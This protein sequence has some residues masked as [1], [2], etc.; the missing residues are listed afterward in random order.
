MFS[1]TLRPGIKPVWSKLIILGNTVFILFA[2]VP[3][4]ILYIVFKRVIGRKFFMKC[5]GLP[6]LGIHVIIP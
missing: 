1:P 5:F 4:G 3:E 6:S 2:R